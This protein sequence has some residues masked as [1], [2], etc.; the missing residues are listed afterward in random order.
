MNIG[1]PDTKN[2]QGGVHSPLLKRSWL[3]KGWRAAVGGVGDAW[4]AGKKLVKKTGA[5]I[6]SAFKGD[7]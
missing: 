7:N 4:R 6:G 1:Y 3:G 2:R 5:D